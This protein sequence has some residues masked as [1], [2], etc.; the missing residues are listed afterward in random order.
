MVQD[1]LQCLNS[2][3]S[4]RLHLLLHFGAVLLVCASETEGSKESYGI[5]DI[6]KI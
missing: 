4:Y 5:L 3:P 6:G 1:R 2:W